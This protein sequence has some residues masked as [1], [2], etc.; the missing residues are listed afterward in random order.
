MNT[1]DTRLMNSHIVETDFSGILS[2]YF[3]NGL[4]KQ[5][6]SKNNIS[7]DHSRRSPTLSLIKQLEYLS[8]ISNNDSDLPPNFSRWPT[9]VAFDD[10]RAFVLKLPLMKI[11]MPK[12]LLAEDGEIN[13]VWENEECYVDLG[14]YGTGFY[15]YFARNDQGKE[16]MGERID[17]HT[18]LANPIIDLLSG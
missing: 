9:N 3:D 8:R 12:I 14:F 18:G 17:V 1:F 7:C 6:V 10:A 13:F 11:S 16:I 2:D 5:E 15:S 4:F